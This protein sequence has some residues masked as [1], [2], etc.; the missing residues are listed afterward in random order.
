MKKNKIDNPLKV[1]V[2][3]IPEFRWAT[4]YKCPY[5]DKDF[6]DHEVFAHSKERSLGMGCGTYFEQLI[7]CSKCSNYYITSNGT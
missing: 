2:D 7:C 4:K 6:Q 1:M 3:G 5:C